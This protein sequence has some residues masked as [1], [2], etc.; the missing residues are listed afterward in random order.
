[1]SR[2]ESDRSPSPEEP[3][4]TT[5]GGIASGHNYSEHPVLT[6]LEA[7]LVERSCEPDVARSIATD[8][9]KFYR[10]AVHPKLPGEAPTGIAVRQTEVSRLHIWLYAAWT[11]NWSVSDTEQ[12]RDRNELS[13]LFVR[14]V[15]SSFFPNPRMHLDF[16]PVDRR[17]ESVEEILRQEAET[18]ETDLLGVLSQPKHKLTTTRPS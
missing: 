16:L 17:C 2:L 9:H 3:T 15:A 10:S 5:S 8:I 4:Y 1:M 7:W 14:S 13:K 11:D 12:V 18:D 6:S